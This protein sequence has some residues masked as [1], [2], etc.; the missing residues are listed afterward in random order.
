VLLDAG[1]FTTHSR[2]SPDGRRIAYVSNESGRAEVYVCNFEGPPARWQVSTEGGIDP[3]WA[4]NGRELFYIAPNQKMMSV[5]IVAGPDFVPGI[6][7]ELMTARYDPL[8]RNSYCVS[9]D[10]QRFLFLIPESDQNWPM[11]VVVNWQASGERR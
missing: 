2:F 3:R 11:T 7:A 4:P 5:P 8:P 6:P 10:G 9:P 1:V